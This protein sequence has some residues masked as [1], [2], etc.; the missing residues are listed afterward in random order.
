GLGPR[1]EVVL[2]IKRSVAAGGLSSQRG[3]ATSSRNRGVGSKATQS[4]VGFHCANFYHIRNNRDSK[5]SSRHTRK[6]ACDGRQNAAVVQPVARRSDRFRSSR[7]LRGSHK[8][9]TPC[10]AS[11]RRQR[12]FSRHSA[13]PKSGRMGSRTLPDLALGQSYFL[14]SSI[15]RTSLRSGN[16]ANTLSPFCGV[17]NGLS[18]PNVARGIGGDAGRSSAPVLRHERS[19]NFGCRPRS[20]V[21]AQTWH[22]RSRFTG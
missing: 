3:A 13:H 12:R 17:G 11:A 2:W 22:G 15:G 19:W 16:Q 18:S 20:A 21:Q 4:R 5:V 8:D 7:V 6:L 10:T 9:F 14:P 1:A